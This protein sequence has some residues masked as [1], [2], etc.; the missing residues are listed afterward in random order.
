MKKSAIE[1]PDELLAL[2]EG[3]SP[4]PFG[5]GRGGAL[6]LHA[7]CA[8]CSSAIVEW[9]LAHGLR[10]VIF[11][12]NPNIYPREEYEIRKQESKR[13]ADSLGV[14]WID[15]DYDHE[16]WK[17]DVCGLENEPERG[18]R[19]ELCFTLRLTETARKAKELGLT[20]FT[21]TL[22]SSR[23]K[24]IEQITRAGQA[25][26]AAV[27]GT[28]FWAQ[29]WRKGGLYERRNELLREYNFYNQQYC[30]CEYSA[31][32]VPS[33]GR[34]AKSGTAHNSESDSVYSEIVAPLPSEGQGE[35][36]GKPRH[37]A[38]S[39]S[40]LYQAMLSVTRWM[41]RYY[42]DGV[43]GLVPGGI[44]DIV[45]AL[46]AVVHVYFSAFRLRSIPL[47]LAI[48]N[49]TL[50]DIFLGMLPFFVGDVIDF[51]HKANKKNMALIDGFL[52]NDQTVIR[53]VNRKA[54]QS[55]VVLVALVIGIILI[56]YGLIWLTKTL[57]TA[58]FS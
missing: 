51:F 37:E 46:F 41:D 27:P 40:R 2:Q 39:S 25:A 9:L 44:G 54:I 30:G 13:H 16:K 42:L 36:S 48:L 32:P 4:S 8:P 52:R 34:G 29:N 10:P 31:S 20:W 50:R 26:E 23:W 47:T 55:A 58:L 12:Y 1:I 6:L 35:A 49:N 28:R 15:G 11:Y 17:H 56:V 22:A 38:L 3:M 24:S 21:T 43:A 7:C 33:E 5:E 57:G 19:C 53:E 18:R 14:Q 45:S